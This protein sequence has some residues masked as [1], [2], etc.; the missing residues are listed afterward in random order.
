MRKPQKSNRKTARP[1]GGR[2]SAY[3]TKLR[4]LC[5]SPELM[6]KNYQGKN[7]KL[8][9][10]INIINDSSDE[11]ILVFSQFTKVL[12]VIGKRLNE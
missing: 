1:C 7:S 9:V 10:L 11:K 12:E 4:Q 3:L 6:V 8:D 2:Y 5:L